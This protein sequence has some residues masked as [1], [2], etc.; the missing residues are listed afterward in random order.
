MALGSGAILL[1]ALPPSIPMGAYNEVQ[2]QSGHYLAPHSSGVRFDVLLNTTAALVVS[3][4]V[5][6]MVRFVFAKALGSCMAWAN[7]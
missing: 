4:V 2:V 3:L 7:K 6:E 1:F 5:Y